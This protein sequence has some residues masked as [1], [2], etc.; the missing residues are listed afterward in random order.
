[1]KKTKNKTK[2]QANKKTKKLGQDKKT[3][4]KT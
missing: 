1:M 2:N 3:Q 4:K